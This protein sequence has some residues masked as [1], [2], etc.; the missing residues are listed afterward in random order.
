M[1]LKFT[2]KPRAMLSRFVNYHAKHYSRI[3][4]IA[5]L[6]VLFWGKSDKHELKRVGN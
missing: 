3:G 6:F 4:S 2:C 5:L 1:Q